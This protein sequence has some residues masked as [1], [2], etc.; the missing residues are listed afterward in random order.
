MG[1]L[2]KHVYLFERRENTAQVLLHNRKISTDIESDFGEEIFMDVRYW[3]KKGQ[4][5]LMILVKI[6]CVVTKWS[7]EFI[8]N[9][10]ILLPLA[11]KQKLTLTLYG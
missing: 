8:E 3:A 9:T 2:W 6:A 11:N 10:G 1:S 5:K 7:Q 4:K